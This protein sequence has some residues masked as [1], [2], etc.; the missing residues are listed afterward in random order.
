MRLDV[1]QAVKAL[2]QE[3]LTLAISRGGK[4][5]FTS[6]N[7]GVQDLYCLMKR[8]PEILK[9]ASAADKVVGKA[10]A[11][12][13]AA[14]GIKELYADNLSRAA[15]SI[16]REAGVKV[17]YE[18]MIP[19]VMNRDRSGMCPVERLATTMDTL[20]QLMTGLAYFYKDLDICG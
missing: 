2:R 8:N 1:N 14:S 9:G 17:Q 16:L 4:V 7:R 12:L 3:H 15:A 13:Y 11:M 6:R 10:A 19:F 18:N 20:E 5:I